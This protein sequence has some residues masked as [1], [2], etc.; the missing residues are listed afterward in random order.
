MTELPR[1]HNSHQSVPATS[2]PSTSPASEPQPSKPL[3]LVVFLENVGHIQGVPLP[4][5]A[6]NVVDFVTE[7]Y[8]K[9]LLRLYGA[10]RRYRRV[11]ILEDAEATGAKLAE[12]LVEA[13]REHR[14][15]V[16]LL[17]HGQA[18]CLVGYRGVES[19]GDETFGP[20]LEAY[21]ENPGL[22]DLRAVYGLNCFGVSLA[23]TWLALGAD[24]VNGAVGVN[25]LPEPSLSVF[26]RNWLGGK[27]FS[28]AV[29]ASH[30]VALRWGQ[31]V[32]PMDR[33]GRD[34]PRIAG[35]RQVIFGRR[36]VTIGS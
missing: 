26:L 27:T 15:D 5:W 23:S 32:W 3:A 19:V 10:Y 13:S 21:R 6:Q 12:A 17:V 24:V 14:V 31:R 25:W 8:A 22:L 35:S 34:H 18:R 1:A 36:D 30:A 2:L 7:E 11:I 29:Q 9:L 20:L 33:A 28:Q 16:L 4:Q